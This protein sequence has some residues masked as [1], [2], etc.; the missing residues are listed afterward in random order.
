M[1]RLLLARE[2]LAGL[3]LLRYLRLTGLLLGGESGLLLLSG[4]ELL[5]WCLLGGLAVLSGG[6]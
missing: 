5:A 1:S 2:L 6:L 4:R 3:M